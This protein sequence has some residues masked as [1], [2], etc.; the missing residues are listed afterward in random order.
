MLAATRACSA[1]AERRMSRGRGGDGKAVDLMAMDDLTKRGEVHGDELLS[2]SLSYAF[3][4]LSINDM[5]HTEL[6][7]A[8]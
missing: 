7:Q 1:V 3:M 4:L 5:L 2:L 6:L 8:P